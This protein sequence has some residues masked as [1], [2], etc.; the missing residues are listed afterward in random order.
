VS[1]LGIAALVAA[2]LLL[3]AIL[4]WRARRAASGAPAFR[5]WGETG[6]WLVLDTETT[7]TG[8]KAEIIEIAVI[9]AR[10]NTLLHR[11]VDP[12]ERITED[13]RRV[14]K[15]A[16]EEVQHEPSWPDIHEEVS[17]IL[18]DRRVLAYNAAFDA[19]VLRQTAKRYGLEV[20]RIRWECVMK[21]YARLVGRI[22]PVNNTLKHHRL[23]H[24]AEREG[25][26]VEGAHDA[27]SDCRT[28]LALIQAVSRRLAS[29]R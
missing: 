27:L 6:D 25:V 3:G 12:A 14:H 13:S 16:D 10:G 8:S 9:D 22:E 28:T 29:E 11:K 2:A 5:R 20:P 26:R 23:V 1:E 7:R 21:A 24:A 19:R 17:A 15:I 18:R 4:V